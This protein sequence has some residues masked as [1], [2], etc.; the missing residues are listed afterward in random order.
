VP[1]GRPE[2]G[3]QAEVARVTRNARVVREAANKEALEAIR[4][5]ER[6]LMMALD[7]ER[8]LQT[9]NLATANAPIYGYRIR[10][11]EPDKSLGWR[12]R[13][14]LVLS[15]KGALHMVW[16][17]RE[18]SGWRDALD[19]ELRG[20]DLARVLEVIELA[21]DRHL[22]KA[23]RRTRRFDNIRSLADKVQFILGEDT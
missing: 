22:Q 14:T 6:T 11:R 18:G 10:C 9:P 1:E 17:S 19:E 15:A 2:Y 21:T 12:G 5:A 7:G 8:L 4:K 23:E 13:P 3:D 16:R 20:E